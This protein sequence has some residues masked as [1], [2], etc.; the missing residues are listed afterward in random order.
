MGEGCQWFF[1]SRSSIV[2][3]DQRPAISIQ[4]CS[5]RRFGDWAGKE[6]YHSRRIGGDYTAPVVSNQMLPQAA[7]IDAVPSALTE[8]VDR[9]GTDDKTADH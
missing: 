1:I 6:S 5:G 2:I 4:R 8:G 9:L 7:T 3:S